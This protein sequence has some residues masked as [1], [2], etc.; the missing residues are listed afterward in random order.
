MECIV[1]D[2]SA[3]RML[4]RV[5][6]CVAKIGDE[7]TF[8]ASPDGL[9]I[10]TL[11]ASRSAC[12][13]FSVHSSFFS[14]FKCSNPSTSHGRDAQHEVRVFARA[15]LPIFRAPVAIGRLKIAFSTSQERLIFD[16]VSRSAVKKTFRLPVLDGSVGR[17]LVTKEACSSFI[18]CRPKFLIDV[19]ANFHARLDEITFAPT[20][21]SLRVSSFV[22]DIASTHHQILRTEMSIDSREFDIFRMSDLVENDETSLTFYCK[23]FRAV[24]EFCE[25]ADSPLSIWFHES[26]C[27]MIFEIEQG[28]LAATK[29]FEATFI[30]ATRHVEHESQPQASNSTSKESAR[31]SGQSFDRRRQPNS[32]EPNPSSGKESSRNTGVR[33][34]RQPRLSLTTR[35]AGNVSGGTTRSNETQ[36]NETLSASGQVGELAVAERPSQTRE[37]QMNSG[38]LQAGS[39]GTTTA[40]HN[41]QPLHGESTS[42]GGRQDLTHANL[43]LGDNENDR[44]NDDEYVDGTPPPSP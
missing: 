23:P 7:V 42:I 14:T 39:V 5:V 30:F 28:L 37:N 11:N 20:T 16:I 41:V 26:G 33:G 6:Q 43:D 17:P 8:R 40:A 9:H 12:A 44:G 24:L 2:Y 10:R 22:D 21:T 13:E 38:V 15:L 35:D 29:Q 31:V 27:P 25:N 19:L 4:A 32:P 34:S 36:N 18:Q 1:G 3:V